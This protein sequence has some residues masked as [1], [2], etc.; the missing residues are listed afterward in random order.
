M[1][2]LQNT[3][4]ALRD[5]ADSS[6]DIYGSFEKGS[7]A[8]ETDITNQIDGIG[9][10]DEQQAKIEGLRSRIHDGRARVQTL[11]ARVD[12]V[13]ERVE[14]WERADQHWQERTRRRL[15]YIWTVMSLTSLLTTV[16]F[17][18]YRF[19]TLDMSAAGLDE[20]VASAAELPGYGLPNASD[21]TPSLLEEVDNQAEEPLLWTKPI[22][23]DDRLRGL[24][25]L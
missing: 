2:A 17:M 21:R 16:L 23:D 9:R 12:A 8:I 22:R 19:G 3:I 14:S 24:D 4:S 15:K 5:L 13:R 10:F 18:F 6:R 7:R 1:S 20:I 11:S 25:E